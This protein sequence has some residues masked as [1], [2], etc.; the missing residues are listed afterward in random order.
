MA[1][2]RMHTNLPQTFRPTASCMIP[3][4]SA[5]R[6]SIEQS[7]STCESTHPCSQT[8]LVTE[9]P[10]KSQHHQ[11][12]STSTHKKHHMAYPALSTVT[13]QAMRKQPSKP[14]VNHNKQPPVTRSNATPV[15]PDLREP[16]GSKPKERQ[17]K[18]HYPHNNLFL[19]RSPFR[20]FP[21]EP[22]GLS[23]I[24]VSRRTIYAH[25]RLDRCAGIERAG[26]SRRTRLDA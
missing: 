6:Q 1:V 12:M 22:S 10:A 21:D 8:R 19:D 7:T 16:S 15:L 24:D 13:R 9:R 14:K 26:P 3:Y 18:Q 23:A 4:S 11:P 5:S 2:W 20:H 25:G 17:S